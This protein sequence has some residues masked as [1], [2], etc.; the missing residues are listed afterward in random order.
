MVSS[1][2][3][4]RRTFSKVTKKQS[5]IIVKCY[6]VEQSCSISV[7]ITF[8]KD[9]WYD[10]LYLRGLMFRGLRGFMYV[11]FACYSEQT[12]SPGG[13]V[14]FFPLNHVMIQ[15]VCVR[16]GVGGGLAMIKRFYLHWL[17]Y[18]QSMLAHH[19]E[20]FNEC[21]SSTLNS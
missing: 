2:R 19:E 13:K 11:S 18:I 8:N 1:V 3:H 5:V 21:H 20:Q 4:V 6:S 10:I 14:S 16:A 12:L 7:I 15:C 9:E 17:F